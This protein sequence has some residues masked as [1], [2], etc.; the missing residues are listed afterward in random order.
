MCKLQV[1]LKQKETNQFP[2]YGLEH[3]LPFSRKTLGIHLKS[4]MSIMVNQKNC[5]MNLKKVYEYKKTL[6]GKKKKQ[7][8][9]QNKLQKLPRGEA[10]AKKDKDLRKELH[11]KVQKTIKR[12]KLCGYPFKDQNCAGNVILYGNGNGTLKKLN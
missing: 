7:I 8:G 2:Q 4:C 10:Q 11:N 12:Y 9:C 1:K 5:G 3:I 6:L